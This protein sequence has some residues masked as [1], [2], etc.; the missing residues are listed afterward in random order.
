MYPSSP[1][2]A[3]IASPLVKQIHL[4]RLI[5]SIE[6]VRYTTAN[7]TVYSSFTSHL[8]VYSMSLALQ[9]A[10]EQVQDTSGEDWSSDSWEDYESTSSLAES[11]S[12]L[13][14]WASSRPPDYTS[15]HAYASVSDGTTAL[16]TQNTPDGVKLFLFHH[17]PT[18]APGSQLYYNPALYANLPHASWSPASTRIPPELFDNVLFYLCLVSGPYRRRN[19]G[20]SRRA[21]MSCSLVCLRWANICRQALFRDKWLKI[22]SSE[23][24]QTF[25]KYATQRIPSLIPIHEL[26]ESILVEQRY[27]IQYSFCDRV[28]MLKAKFGVSFSTLRL[29]GPVPDGFPSCRLDTPH[30]GLSPSVPTPPSLLSYDEIDVQNVHLPSFRHVV[31]YVRHFAQAGSILFDGLTWDT[32]GQEPQ[33]PFYRRGSH[34]VK[35]RNL[36]VSANGC[37]DNMILCLLAV[38]VHSCWRSLMCMVPDGESQWITI[39]IRWLQELV[40]KN[41]SRSLQVWGPEESKELPISVINAKFDLNWILRFHLCNL[42]AENAQTSD[43]HVVC[44]TLEVTGAVRKFDID[45]LIPYLGHFPML[46]VVL[47]RFYSY[48]ALLAAMK[49]HRPLSFNPLS[50]NGQGCSCIFMSWRQTDKD[51]PEVPRADDI[52]CDYVEICPMTLSP[53]GRSW[54]SG[55]DLEKQATSLQFSP[56]LQYHTTIR[57]YRLSYEPIFFVHRYS[58]DCHG[59]VLKMYVYPAGRAVCSR[60]RRTPSATS[61]APHSNQGAGGVNRYDPA[62][63][64]IIHLR[65]VEH[66]TRRGWSSAFAMIVLTASRDPRVLRKARIGLG[67][68]ERSGGEQ[69]QACR[70]EGGWWGAEI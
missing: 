16:H 20:L 1:V 46:H 48:E 8:R 35:D 53:T 9:D 23:E 5:G 25:T 43:V 63:D 65:Y 42:A 54:D 39:T 52:G 13:E 45:S 26:I 18:T 67:R 62:V 66:E 28:Y 38:T 17:E 57:V 10:R 68:V 64:A 7:K 29:T 60:R 50:V 4:S 22:R 70:G 41:E 14:Q 51:F 24:L 37:T 27:D 30:W 12:E 33:L 69:R 61:A 58:E 34:K 19:G 2:V 3:A 40:G 15:P 31:K 59:M 32:D 21:V 44:I 47:L 49:R 6:L 55:F 36:R 56:E 11:D